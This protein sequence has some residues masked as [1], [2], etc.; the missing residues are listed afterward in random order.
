FR[1][2]RARKRFADASCRAGDERGLSLQR[3]LHGFVEVGQ[4]PSIVW[5]VP[6][7]TIRGTHMERCARA[8]SSALCFLALCTSLPAWAADAASASSSQNYPTRPIRWLVPAPPGGGTDAVSRIMS[9]RLAEILGQQIVVDNRGGAQG[10]I[11]TA[12]TAKS[13]PD[14]YTILFAYSGT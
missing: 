10:S 12:L 9:P 4:R 5:G 3:F 8:F 6:S 11:A 13:P 2:E 1:G 14:G 7:K